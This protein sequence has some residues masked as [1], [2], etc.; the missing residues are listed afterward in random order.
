MSR[1]RPR[2]PL[3]LRALG[4]A[5]TVLVALVDAAGESE[6]LA[7]PRP[8][9]HLL[10]PPP[11]A[12]T[13]LRP[14][15][16][17]VPPT[18]AVRPA[19]P[20]DVVPSRLLGA[21]FALRRAETRLRPAVTQAA[22]L[23]EVVAKAVPLPEL[24]RSWRAR[25]AALLARRAEPTPLTELDR[26]LLRTCVE[27]L[28]RAAGGA[29]EDLALA[30]IYERVPIGAI[31]GASARPGGMELHLR[32]GARARAGVLVVG[33]RRS[34]GELVTA[35]VPTGTGSHARTTR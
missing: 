16:D 26:E 12:A 15:I 28:Y 27:Q 21:T 33:R 32:P 8:E 24:G 23:L 17:D 11:A 13:S 14:E 7:D 19:P 30:G 18:I 20:V 9:T 29:V 10:E 6:R 25:P 3:A 31:A 35:E 5:P 22:P 2:A 1:G 4:S 34:S